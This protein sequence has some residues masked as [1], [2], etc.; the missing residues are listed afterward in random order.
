M[1]TQLM[2]IDW[3]INENG[4][5]EEE[6][7]LLLSAQGSSDVEQTFWREESAPQAGEQAQKEMLD[8]LS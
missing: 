7:E 1:L 5:E 4:A 6:Q 3:L 2:L 8:L